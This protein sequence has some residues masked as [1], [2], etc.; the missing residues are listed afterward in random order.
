V[1]QEVVPKILRY[2]IT[3]IGSWG[4]G[5]T[6]IPLMFYLK[7]KDYLLVSSTNIF[8]TIKPTAT[9]VLHKQKQPPRQN[10]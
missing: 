6:P 8:N 7:P 9:R 5:G 3:S 4:H 1:E 2:L 10:V